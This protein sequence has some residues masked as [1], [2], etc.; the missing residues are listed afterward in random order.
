MDALN[1]FQEALTAS[2]R[3]ETTKRPEI[4][5]AGCKEERILLCTKW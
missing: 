3:I 5:L 1:E 2:G 4:S